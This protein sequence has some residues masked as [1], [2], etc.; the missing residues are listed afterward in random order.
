MD[1]HEQLVFYYV[2]LVLYKTTMHRFILVVGTVHYYLCSIGILLGY[3]ALEF[4]C[5]HH[6]ANRNLLI[7]L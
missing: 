2:I 3:L 4:L 1:L 5:A 7:H 6:C